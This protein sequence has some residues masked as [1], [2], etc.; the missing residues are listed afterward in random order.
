MMLRHSSSAKRTR[1]EF[2]IY[3]YPYDPVSK[4][5]LATWNNDVISR[6]DCII[7]SK[8]LGLPSWI[9]LF[10]FLLGASLQKPPK[11]T[12]IN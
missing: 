3:S 9:F 12:K 1:R 11:M 8:Q 5:A 7:I 10:S 2:N 6:E 4:M